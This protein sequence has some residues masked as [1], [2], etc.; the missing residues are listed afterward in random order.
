MCD[1]DASTMNRW[2][3]LS[4]FDEFD[5]ANATLLLPWIFPRGGIGGG[6]WGGDDRVISATGGAHR[7]TGFFVATRSAHLHA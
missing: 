5:V 7:D 3:P 4:P 2:A 6:G 1:D